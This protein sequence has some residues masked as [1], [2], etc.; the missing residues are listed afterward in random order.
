MISSLEYAW[1]VG[2]LADLLEARSGEGLDLHAEY[3]NPQMVRVLRTIGFDRDW[4]RTDGVY[5]YDAT[6]EKYLV[7]PS[8]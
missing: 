1:P 6:G 7:N 2:E 3:V 4:V 8:L 5:L